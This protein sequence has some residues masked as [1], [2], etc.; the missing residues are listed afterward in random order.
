MAVSIKSVL[1]GQYFGGVGICT[2][3]MVQAES[4]L[5]QARFLYETSPLSRPMSAEFEALRSHG[6]TVVE[7]PEDWVSRFGDEMLWRTQ[8]VKDAVRKVKEINLSKQDSTPQMAYKTLARVVLVALEDVFPQEMSHLELKQQLVVEPSD[9]ELLTILDG[10]HRQGFI[11]GHIKRERM[12]GQ[13]KLAAMKGIAITNA[14]MQELKDKPAEQS[15]VIQHFTNYGQAGALGPNAVGTIN[16]QQQWADLS[17]NV[18]LTQLSAELES[19][20][21][22]LVKT[23]KSSDDFAKL[24]IVAEAEGHAQRHDGPRAVEALA[25]TGKWL[26][27]FATE[28]GSDITAK[29]VAKALHLEP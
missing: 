28:V 9:E 18:D 16:N 24:S 8:I 22:T 27:D 2:P 14:G 1:P 17:R 3:Y 10:L 4:F 5:K 19:L 26:F 21:T 11:D 6:F 25:K 7:A 29:V 15:P 20:R 23:A 13:H 12:S